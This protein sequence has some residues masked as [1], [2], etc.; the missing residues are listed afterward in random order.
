MER[1]ISFSRRAR[2]WQSIRLCDKEIFLRSRLPQRTETALWSEAP[3]RE[4]W[5][6]L[7]RYSGLIKPSDGQWNPGHRCQSFFAAAKKMACPERRTA[8]RQKYRKNLRRK[9]LCCPGKQKQ[10]N[11]IRYKAP[12]S[13][14]SDKKRHPKNPKGRQ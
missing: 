9:D 2:S 10:E 1:F 13:R 14:F 11:R 3:E 4:V 7:C 5:C 12:E 8:G 6:R